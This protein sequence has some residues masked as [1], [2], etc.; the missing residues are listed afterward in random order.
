VNE[1]NKIIIYSFSTFRN[2]FKNIIYKITRKHENDN[3]LETEKMCVTGK[4]RRLKGNNMKIKK[5]IE[6][7]IKCHSEVNAYF[8]LSA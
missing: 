1:K 3:L 8:V 4:T 5:E 7:E 2:H 6:K